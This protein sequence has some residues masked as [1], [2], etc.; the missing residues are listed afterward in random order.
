MAHQALDAINP[1]GDN[2]LVQGWQELEI[3]KQGQPLTFFFCSG[4]GPVGLFAIAIAK[5]MG[6]TK[7]L[8][9]KL[10]YA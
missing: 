4:C 5:A 3:K 6:A 8:V 10:P 7:V 1:K 2:V 9:E